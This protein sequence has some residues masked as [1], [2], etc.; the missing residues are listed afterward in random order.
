MVSEW[1]DTVGF[2]LSEVGVETAAETEGRGM[3]VLAPNP[4]RGNVTVKPMIRGDE[5][6][7]MLTVSD[8]KGREMLHK[9]LSRE[10]Q[11]Y[12]FRVSDFPAGTY[13]VTLA[14]KEGSSTRKLVVE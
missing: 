5:Y 9:E 14:T 8:A 10:T 12:T 7:A 11:E 1:S 13:F 3:F 2:T 6:P 4:A